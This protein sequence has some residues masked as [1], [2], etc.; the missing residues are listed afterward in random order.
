MVADVPCSGTGV[1]KRKP[2]SKW[3]ITEDKLI[4]ILVEQK[5][6][7]SDSSR[8]VRKGGTLAYVTCS[9]LKSENQEQIAW[10]LSKD[11]TFSFLA[12]KVLLPI[13]GG[14]GFYVSLL[15]KNC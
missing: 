14:D 1:W 5:K 11:I 3:L 13:H 6:I 4:S 7:L 15:I 8:L 10:F 12:D 9:V 2:G